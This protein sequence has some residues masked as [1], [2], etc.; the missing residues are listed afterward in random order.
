MNFQVI[1]EI[2]L[3]ILVLLFGLESPIRHGHIQTQVLKNQ[4]FVI[5]ALNHTF[6]ETSVYLHIWVSLKKLN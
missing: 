1:F 3:H 5:K 2:N 4:A 6:Y